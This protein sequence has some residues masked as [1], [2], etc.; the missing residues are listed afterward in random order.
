[1]A[2]ISAKQVVL[3][4]DVNLSSIHWYNWLAP[5]GNASDFL[6]LYTFA[7]LRIQQCASFHIRVSNILNSVIIPKKPASVSISHVSDV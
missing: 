4:G 7:S 1:M 5:V 3:L 6:F 2:T